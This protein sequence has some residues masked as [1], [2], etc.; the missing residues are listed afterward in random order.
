[1]S[2][3]L[4]CSLLVACGKD[5]PKADESVKPAPARAEQAPAA[6]AADG[7]AAVVTAPAGDGDVAEAVRRERERAEAAGR[8]LVVYVG[9]KWCEPCRRFKE[10]VASGSLDGHFGGVTFYEFD[11]DRDERRLRP[12]G[13]ASQMIPLFALPAADGKAS[14]Q[15]L[16]GAIS[17]DGAVGWIIPRLRR[18]LG[19]AQQ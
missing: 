8:H 13:Y 10:A 5:A 1:M 4:A 14:K 15:Q 12:A 19:S 3:W 7:K 6:P 17:G 18:L 9:A 2:L 16:M 11:F